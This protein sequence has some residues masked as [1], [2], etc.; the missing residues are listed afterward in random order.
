MK[1]LEPKHW[2]LNTVKRWSVRIENEI[3]EFY[4]FDLCYI[5]ALLN[6]CVHTIQYKIA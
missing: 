5:A 1:A 6:D 4:N 3:V 2:H